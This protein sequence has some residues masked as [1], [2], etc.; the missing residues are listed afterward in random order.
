MKNEDLLEKYRNSE[1]KI[2]EVFGRQ[3]VLLAYI[4]GSVPRK[5]AGPLSDID[6]AVYFEE[7]LPK[8]HRNELYLDIINNLTETLGDEIDLVKMN[9]SNILLKFNIIKSGEIIFQKSE[10]DKIRIESEIMRK[11]LDTKYY[12]KR[13][14]DANIHRI[15]ERGLK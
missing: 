2:K 12:R 15:A 5:D 1:K 3:G 11:N 8:S 4:F 7:S 14:V 10:D 13:H 6:F 9:D